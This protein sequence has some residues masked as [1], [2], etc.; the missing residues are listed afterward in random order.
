[1]N[2]HL[3]FALPLACCVVLV[4][5]VFWHAAWSPLDAY[6]ANTRMTLETAESVNL[7]KRARQLAAPAEV[8]IF[9]RYDNYPEDIHWT[10]T[11]EQSK[12]VLAEHKGNK[13]D[14]HQE[15]IINL[16][17]PAGKYEFLMTDD[18]GDGLCC[19]PGDFK[20]HYKITANNQIIAIGGEFAD[21]TG[22]IEFE[23][24]NGGNVKKLQETNLGL[25]PDCLEMHPGNFNICLYL[26]TRAENFGNEWL[27][28]FRAA[29]KKW[30]TII[31]DDYTEPTS[32]KHNLWQRPKTLDGVFITGQAAPI[33][34]EMGILGSS[35]PRTMV[36]STKRNPVNHNKYFQQTLT[37][38][39]TFDSADIGRMLREKTYKDV[40]V[41]EM[42]H[43]LGLVSYT[44]CWG[45][46]D[47][48][49]G[50]NPDTLP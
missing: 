8:E 26:T 50:T 42:G 43:V 30:E 44:E 27:P 10:L 5:H 37:G 31:V 3:S 41:H 19:R 13:T 11:D 49:Y 46:A 12:K 23:T 2:R 35:G 24:F 29:K 21:S 32:F 20:G 15:R 6:D 25:Q 34:G 28:A 47:Q 9:V 38:E 14:A 39:M 45:K 7:R 4:G 17:V 16:Q 48:Q 33:D 1:M 18:H 36:T 22:P 40:I